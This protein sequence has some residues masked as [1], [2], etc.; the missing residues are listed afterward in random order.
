MCSMRQPRPKSWGNATI[1]HQMHHDA[2]VAIRLKPSCKAKT[3]CT[4]SNPG[5]SVT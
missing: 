2:Q 4:T 3:F 5:K 1:A